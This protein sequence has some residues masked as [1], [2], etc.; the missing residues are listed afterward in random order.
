MIKRYKSNKKN[1]GQ[2]IPR[3]PTKYVGQYPIIVRSSWERKFCQWLDANLTVFEW[4]SE[5]IA[6]PYYDP[7]MMKRRRYFPDFWMKIKN[8]DD[9]VDK[10][11]IEIKPHKECVPPKK[12]RKKPSTL[13]LQEA[14][15]LTNQAKFKAAT[16][17]CHKLGYKFKILTEKELFNK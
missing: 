8:R 4:S 15:Y 5:N 17:Y 10:Y 7:V 1:V 12:G 6:I 14:T 13:R 2:Y 9:S 11:I 3:N 16:D